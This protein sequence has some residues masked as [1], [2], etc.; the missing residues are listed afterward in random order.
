M[1]TT[2]MAAARAIVMLLFAYAGTIATAGDGSLTG[3]W[4]LSIESPQGKRTPHM[5]LAQAGNLVSGTYKS[6][7]GELPVSGRITGEEF[8]LE[9]KMTRQGQEVLFAYR[10]ILAG[11]DMKGTLSM[12]KMGDVPF[13]GSRAAPE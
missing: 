11:S 1:R 3:T 4:N 5:T 13:T 6:H 12:G 10:G 2:R 7:M 9:V 8:V